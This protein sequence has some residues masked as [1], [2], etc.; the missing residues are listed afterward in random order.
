MR[1]TFGT[2]IT[3]LNT[4]FSKFSTVRYRTENFTVVVLLFMFF[5]FKDFVIKIILGNSLFF[6][7]FL[8]YGISIKEV[9]CVFDVAPILPPH[10]RVTVS[11]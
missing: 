10:P 3:S 1:Y 11:F 5:H 4:V 6:F 2:V 8:R 7:Q 9:L